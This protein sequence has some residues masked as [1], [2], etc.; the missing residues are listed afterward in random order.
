LALCF[1]ASLLLCFSASLLLCLVVRDFMG[2]FDNLECS[3]MLKCQSLFRSKTD[4]GSI[5]SDPELSMSSASRQRYLTARSRIIQKLV[6]NIPS[7]AFPLREF[8]CRTH[9]CRS[10]ITIE[11]VSK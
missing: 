2:H 9:S 8:Q 10:I 7:I 1:F 6:T 5:L 11:V 4:S 3:F